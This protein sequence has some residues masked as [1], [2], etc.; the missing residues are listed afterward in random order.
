MGYKHIQVPTIGEKIVVNENH[1]LNV[2]DQPI[3]PYIEGDGIGVDISPV[4]ITVVNR[5]KIILSFSLK[6]PKSSSGK[7]TAPVF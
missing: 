7:V 5:N 6:S 4:M 1:I 2:P 3:I